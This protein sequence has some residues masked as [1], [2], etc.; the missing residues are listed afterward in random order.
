MSDNV[1]MMMDLKNNLSTLVFRIYNDWSITYQN[2]LLLFIQ[3]S[4]FVVIS[5]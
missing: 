2:Q 5:A 1:K 4:R 3:G